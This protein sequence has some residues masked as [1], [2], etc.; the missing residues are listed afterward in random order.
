MAFLSVEQ[1]KKDWAENPRWKGIKRGY[2]AEDV[3]RLRGNVPDRVQPRATGRREAVET[4]QHRT[5]RELPGRADRWSGHAAGQGRRSRPSTCPAGRSP[6]TT[7]P[8]CRDVSRPVAVSGRFGAGGGRAHQQLVQ[9]R[10]RNPVRSW[11]RNPGHKDFIDYFLPIV[12]DAE[13]GFGGVLNA[14]N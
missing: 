2:S 10:R 9:A 4:D 14:M 3:V 8:T 13:A 11:H 6:P 5:L 7:T 1:L 12:G